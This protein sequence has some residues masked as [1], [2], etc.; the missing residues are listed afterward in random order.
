[1]K[2]LDEK[3]QLSLSGLPKIMK[4]CFHD[5]Y[6]FNKGNIL[7]KS[8]IRSLSEISPLMAATQ[9]QEE[10]QVQHNWTPPV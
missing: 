6:S 10:E 9:E 7:I 3:L 1:M 5:Y 4:W 8:K 2:S